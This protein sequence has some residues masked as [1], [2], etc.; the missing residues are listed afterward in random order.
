MRILPP[1]TIAVS[2]AHHKLLGSLENMGLSFVDLALVPTEHLVALA[3]CV[4][5]KLCFGIPQCPGV[6]QCTGIPQL[7]YILY[8]LDI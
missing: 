4:T 6:P 1:V 3:S 2:L 7:C 8:E 5:K